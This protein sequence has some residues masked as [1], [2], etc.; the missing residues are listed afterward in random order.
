M[1]HHN[2]VQGSPEW[3]AYRANHFN[4]SDAP[5]MLGLSP[6]KTRTQLL[7]EMKSGI[8]QDIDAATQRR[9]DDG[10]RYEALARPL[11]E[12]IIGQDLYPVTGSNGKLS[13]SF[14]GLTM[15]ETICFEHKT[16]NDEIRTATCAADLGAHLHVQMEQQLMIANAEKCLFMASKWEGDTLVEEVHHWY[17]SDQAMRTAIVQG[18]CQFAEDL[19]NH[20]IAEEVI[21]AVAT[22]TMDLPA[23][24]IQVEGAISLISNLD[25]FGSRLKQFVEEIDKAPTDDQG[26]ANAEQAI[27]TL[28]KA[29]SALEAAESN[30][31]AQTASVDEM[32]KTVDLYKEIARTTRLMLQKMVKARKETIRLEIVQAG[33]SAFAEH[34]AALNK[35]LGKPYMPQVVIDCAGAIKGKKTISSLRD[36]VDT[37]LA[38]AKIEANAIA[39]KIEINLNSLRELAKD[40]SFL[41]ADTQQIIFKENDDLVLLIKSRIADHTAA[42]AA[43]LGAERKR[44]QAEEEAKAKAAQEKIA[45][46]AEAQRVAAVKQEQERIAAEQK[47]AE[48]KVVSNVTSAPVIYPPLETANARVEPYK[49]VAAKEV[50]LEQPTRDQII[51]A[52]AMHFKTDARTAA[53]WIESTFFESAK[54]A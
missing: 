52:V 23:L 29:E 27:K 12:E 17:E 51:F 40:H 8:P 20:V 49:S 26:F 50:K 19:E 30:A 44:I 14:D 53:E 46:E 45:A 31:L 22:P 7:N 34:I 5:A 13:A 21:A 33:N 4:A 24:S 47:T 3:K 9:F 41:F 39:D 35:R 18:W 37:E 32:R 42:E 1:E 15:D 11:A 6:Y 16:L 28:E 25:R 36:A 43:K 2:L 48:A 10:H 38:R 54:A